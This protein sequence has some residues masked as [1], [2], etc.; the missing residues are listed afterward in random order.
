MASNQKAGPV[1]K[2]SSIDE[3]VF[4]LSA[5]AAAQDSEATKQTEECGTWLRDGR[6]HAGVISGANANVRGR[7]CACIDLNKR[8]VRQGGWD[9]IQVTI[10]NGD[11]E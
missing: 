8:V 10:K 4:E 11:N 1:T 9:V 5:A 6:G 2:A 3:A 7:R